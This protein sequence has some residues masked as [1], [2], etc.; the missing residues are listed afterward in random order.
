MYDIRRQCDIPYCTWS[1]KVYCHRMG[2]HEVLP[3]IGL[4][5]LSR[6]TA[7]IVKR[8]RRGE[9]IEITDRGEAIFRMVPVKPADSL[10][11]R[12]VAQGR[13]V[14]PS[15][16]HRREQFLN[17]TRALQ[18]TEPIRELVAL[19]DEGAFQALPEP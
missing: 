17:G 15:T 10:L 12:L 11:D 9:T 2:E 14:P 5:E 19:A 18:G 8:V 6:H 4:R 3:Q 13:A 7:E 1:G 16:D